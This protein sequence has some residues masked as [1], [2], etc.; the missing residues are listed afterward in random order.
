M[1]RI[2]F[3]NYI[4]QTY[5]AKK[6]Y[7]WAKYPSFATFRCGNNKCFAICM[8]ISKNKIGLT[9]DDTIQIVNLKCSP[10]MIS[11][12]IKEQGIFPAYHM[13]KEHWITV[14]LNGAVEQQKL[15]A[16]VDLSYELVAKKTNSKTTLS[17]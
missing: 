15:K 16:L 2:E 9:G 12:L 3:E 7:P 14:L 4:I 17:Y 5:K 8:D 10:F 6:V 11:A 13:S 1:N